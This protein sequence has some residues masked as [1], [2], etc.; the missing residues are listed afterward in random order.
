M[1]RRHPT[2]S[3]PAVRYPVFFSVDTVRSARVSVGGREAE[4]V[5]RSNCAD[6]GLWLTP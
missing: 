5:L 1:L 2:E 4:F 6:L 3:L